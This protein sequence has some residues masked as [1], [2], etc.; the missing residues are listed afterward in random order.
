VNFPDYCAGMD[1]KMGIVRLDKMR[2]DNDSLS[3][4]SEFIPLVFARL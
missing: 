2:N 4:L 3:V 1:L